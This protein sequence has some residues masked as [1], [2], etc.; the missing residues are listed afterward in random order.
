MLYQLLVR[1]YALQEAWGADQPCLVYLQKVMLGL[2]RF[3]AKA[4]WNRGRPDYVSKDTRFLKWTKIVF[5]KR[6][7]ERC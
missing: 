1:S 7:R 4:G 3:R 5:R 2:L 6:K